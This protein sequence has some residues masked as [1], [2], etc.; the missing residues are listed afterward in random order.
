MQKAK[1]CR[2]KWVFVQCE[3][4]WNK[5]K[6]VLNK[7]KKLKLNESIIEIGGN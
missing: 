7:K 3:R 6:R 5:K 2:C 4:G 1:V